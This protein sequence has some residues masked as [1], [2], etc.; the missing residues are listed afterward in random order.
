MR[1]VRGALADVQ[2]DVEVTRQLAELVERSGQPGLR[3]WTPPKQ[4][5]F[6]RR[7]ITRVGYERAREAALERGYVPVE[8]EVG[9][10]AVAYTGETVAFAHL[11]PIDD[12]RTEIRA[13]YRRATDQLASALESLGVYPERGE[14]EASFCPGDHS[15]QHDGKIAGVAQRVRRNCAVVGGCVVVTRRDEEAIAEVLSPVYEALG[16]PFDPNTVG[17]V[18]DVG[19]AGDAGAV[20]DAVESAFVEGRDVEVIE[21]AAVLP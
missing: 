20:V 17:S 7:D 3:V 10:H 13:R 4:V 5:A 9:G 2:R 1:L 15:L 12:D 6:G 16:V 18:E 11:I 21:A 8:R 19:S 14:P